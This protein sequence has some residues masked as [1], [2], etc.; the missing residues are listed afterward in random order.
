MEL[1][2]AGLDGVPVPPKS[3]NSLRAS[4]APCRLGVLSFLV[5]RRP[6][7]PRAHHVELGG[8]GVPQS[9]TVCTTAPFVHLW[10]ACCLPDLILNS[11]HSSGVQ[12]DARPLRNKGDSWASA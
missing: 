9:A 10:S 6:G 4:S 5:S 1:G 2:I 7:W 11:G 3:S 8:D 12:L